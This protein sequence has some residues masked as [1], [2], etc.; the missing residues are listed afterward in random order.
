MRIIKIG[1][2]SGNDIVIDD[3]KVSRTH[4]QIIKDDNGNYRLIDTN[5]ANGTYVNGVQRHG[6]IRLN[7]SD[8]VRIGNTTLPWQTYFNNAGGTEIG[9]SGGEYIPVPEPRKGSGF[10]IAALCCGIV[11]LF[12]FTIILGPLA[13]IF[14]GVSLGRN[15]K[16]KGLGITG[17]VL[18]IIDVRLSIILLVY[19]GSLFFW[20]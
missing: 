5:S 9:K 19:L 3:G 14:G 15:E 17:L 12:F 8:I 10:G 2:S 13:V 16:N 4:C 6:E 20:S 11:G 1:R 7:Q 18:G